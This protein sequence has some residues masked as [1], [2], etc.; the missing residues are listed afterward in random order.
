MAKF[1]RVCES[2]QLRINVGKCKVTRC[3]ISD[4]AGGISVPLNAELLDEVVFL[5][6]GLTCDQERRH[7]SG[8]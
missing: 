5:V 8:G 4:D 2:R 1:G 3:S 6:L 7:R